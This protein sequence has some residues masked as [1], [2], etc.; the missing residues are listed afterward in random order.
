MADA[1]LPAGSV[2]SDI[3]TGR[4]TGWIWTFGTALIALIVAVPILSVILVAFSTDDRGWFDIVQASLP[5]YT[6]N[7]LVLMSGV[8]VGTLTIGIATAWLVTCCRFPGR[9]IFEWALLLP[10]AAPAYLVA[11]VYTDLLEYSGIVQRTLRDIFDWQI[12]A[13]YWFPDIR[14]QG[15]AIIVLSL[16]LY[17]YVYMMG[18]AA[19]LQQSVCALEAARTL[20]RTPW[21]SFWTVALP[22]A[23]PALAIGVSLA[24][25]E[26]LND[27][28]TIDFFGVHTLTAGV[29]EVW[30]LLGSTVGA[31]QLSVVMLLFVVGLLWIERTSRGR[32]RFDHV[33]SKIRALPGYEL[34]GRRKWAAVLVCFLPIAL[35][36]LVPTL[37]MLSDA[38]ANF[39][40]QF[41]RDYL[42]LVYHSFSMA[43]IAALAALVVGLFLAYGARLNGTRALRVLTKFTAIGYAVPGAV[44]GVGI[45][46][47]FTAFDRTFS[48]FMEGT[49][50]IETGAVLFGTSFAVIFAYVVR[51]M[52]IG[53]GAAESALEKV[54]PHM[55][56]AARTLGHGPWSTLKKVHLPMVRGGVLAGAV[57]VFVDC[58]KE[59]PA[60]LLLKPPFNF[61]TLATFAYQ[62]ASD[63]RFEQASLGA[64]TIVLAGILPVIVLSRAIRNARPGHAVDAVRPVRPDT[65]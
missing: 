22:M 31:A 52:A 16:V 44:L 55:D 63:E 60:T 13:D 14:S 56:D 17:P 3:G 4:N 54:T 40:D 51:F 26:T 33:S 8:A 20:G 37:V 19:F 30:R 11:F 6:W 47:P 62:Y 23:R 59:L 29:F 7:T 21:Q 25:M 39:S 5:R 12:K 32:Q 38:I 27:F 34:A 1:I 46:M 42:E 41:G 61:D 64:L 24:M 50:G 49:F 10:L 45:I 18:R 9:R 43:G 58:M 28:G 48:A 15:G 65:V 2:G 36:F 57:L 53:F 35:G